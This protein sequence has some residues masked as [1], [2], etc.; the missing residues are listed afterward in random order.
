[1]VQTWKCIEFNEENQF[2]KVKGEINLTKSLICIFLR[3][4]RKY[5]STQNKAIIT[6]NDINS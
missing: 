1:M 5:C 3:N 6:N 2:V 4:T